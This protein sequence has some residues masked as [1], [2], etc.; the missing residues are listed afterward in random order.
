MPPADDRTPNP[1]AGPVAWRSAANHNRMI[2][3]VREGP[4]QSAG[5]VELAYFGSSAFRITSPSGLTVMIDPWRN[6]PLRHWDWYLR[7][8]PMTPVDIGIST[9]AHFDHDALNCLDAHV[10]LDRLIGTYNFLDVTITGIPDKHATQSGFGT[11][12]FKMVH[13]ELNGV[14]IEPPNNPRSWDNCLIVVETGGL[15]ILHWGDN[16]HDAPDHVWEAL[17][18]IDIA[19]LPVDGSQHVMSFEM[20]ASIIDR[21]KPKVVVPHH[22]YIWDLTTRGSTLMPADGWVAA[23]PHR[24]HVEGPISSYRPDDLTAMATTVDFFGDHVAFDK[25]AWRQGG[26]R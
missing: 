14:E 19:L 20:T 5:H 17:G 21:L 6:H 26:A 23:Q 18:E 13:R 25:L 9:H 22:Y 10:L 4:Q 12:D 24:R 2:D 11:Y 1:N 3:L 7:D 16:R 8:M 15:R